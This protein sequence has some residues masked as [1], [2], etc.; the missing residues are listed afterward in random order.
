MPEKHKD[1]FRAMFGYLA[2]SKIPLAFNCSAGKDRTGIAA[3]LVLTLL[4]VPRETVV[5]DYA[6]SDDIVDY[7]AQM[8][9]SAA[10]N[11]SYAFLTQ[12]PWEVVEPLLASDPA[13]IEAALDAITSKYGS[14]DAF[15]ADEL[16]VTPAMKQTIVE[17][18]TTPA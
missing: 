6:L 9:E 11:P 14:V 2:Q 17:S 13:Y 4:G 8:K 12:L 15:I 10:K 16:G 3:A 7:K 18:Q 5:A 1:S